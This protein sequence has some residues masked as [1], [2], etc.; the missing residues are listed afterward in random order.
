MPT[1][2]RTS[3]RPQFGVLDEESQIEEERKQLSYGSARLDIDALT[4]NAPPE[5]Q[6]NE[7]N[8]ERL[9]SAFQRAGCLRLQPQYHVPVVIAKEVWLSSAI[10]TQSR[11]TMPARAHRDQRDFKIA[12]ICALPLEA[13]CV[14]GVFDKF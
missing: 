12:L 14:Q 1:Q 7:R 9:L 6:G 10:L 8:M 4:F 5:C 13:E 11:P 2:R 3:R